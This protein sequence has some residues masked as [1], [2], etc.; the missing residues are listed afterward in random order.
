[1]LK[2][3]KKNV[4]MKKCVLFLLTIIVNCLFFICR[5]LL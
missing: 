5:H 4:N 3:V 1:M 2:Y